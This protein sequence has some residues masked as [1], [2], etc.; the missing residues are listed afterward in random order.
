MPSNQHEDGLEIVRRC[1]ALGFAA[2]GVCAIEPSERADELRSWLERG[3]H[4]SMGYLAEHL[5]ARLDP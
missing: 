2:A 5:A 4:G 1:R 3:R